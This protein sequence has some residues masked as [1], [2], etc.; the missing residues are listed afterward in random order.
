MEERQVSEAGSSEILVPAFQNTSVLLCTI[1]I[2]IKF[3]PLRTLGTYRQILSM[4][5]IKSQ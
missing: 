1:Q 3:T 2:I 5:E 4:P